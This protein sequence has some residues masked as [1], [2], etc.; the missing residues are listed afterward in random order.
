MKH[1]LK[2]L[3]SKKGMTL[4][5]V[6]IAV[7]IFSLITAAAFSMY[8]PI[9]E[10]AG[11]VRSDNDMQRIVTASENYLARQL[12]NAVEIEIHQTV[13]WASVT[14]DMKAFFENG[15]N[16][17]NKD[18][19]DP[20]A[21]VITTDPTPGAPADAIRIYDIRLNDNSTSPGSFQNLSGGIEKWRVFNTTFYSDIL[22]PTFDVALRGNGALNP[23]PENQVRDDTYLR[24]EIEAE[25]D[26][27][28]GVRSG[29]LASNNGGESHSNILLS[30]IGWIEDSDKDAYNAS[31]LNEA[32][33]C[34]ACSGGNTWVI[35][36]HNNIDMDRKPPEIPKLDTPCPTCSN[37]TCTLVHPA[38]CPGTL[39]CYSEFCMDICVAVCSV[40]N[41]EF[42]HVAGDVDICHF[43]GCPN[44]IN[45]YFVLNPTKCTGK[46]RCLTGAGCVCADRPCYPDCGLGCKTF[47][48]DNAKGR[49]CGAHW[50]QDPCRST[51]CCNC[52]NAPAGTYCDHL[53][54]SCPAF[55]CDYCK[56][57]CNGRPGNPNGGCGQQKDIIKDCLNCCLSCG[58]PPHIGCD[59][60][61]VCN[62]CYPTFP[63][64]NWVED[65]TRPGY[66]EPTCYSEGVMPRYC[67]VCS[68]N[69][70]RPIP[71][72]N[73]KWAGQKWENFNHEQHIKICAAG[74]GYTMHEKHIPSSWKTDD[75]GRRY[76]TCIEA[77]SC[78][79][80]QYDGLFASISKCPT[81]EESVN[82]G[83]ECQRTVTITNNGD[84]AQV[85]G[86]IVAKV[87]PAGSKYVRHYDNEI[88]V[89][90][91]DTEE[92]TDEFAFV[93]DVEILTTQ[94]YEF[95]LT[96][97][98][99][100]CTHEGTG[101]ID[102][103]DQEASCTVA[104]WENRKKCTSCNRVAE[105]TEIPA[106]N[107]VGTGRID[108]DDEEAT[109]TTDGFENRKK[110]GGCF[111]V[112]EDGTTLPA[113]G[114]EPNE[115]VTVLPTCSTPGTKK[116]TCDNCDELNETRPIDALVA[117]FDDGSPKSGVKCGE[118][119][120]IVFK[121]KNCNGSP[122]GHTIE[123]PTGEVRSDNFGEWE[124][125]SPAKC[126]TNQVLKRV[127]L[128]DNCTNFETQD[129]AAATGHDAR[130]DWEEVGDPDDCSNPLIYRCTRC[131]GDE[132]D[133][134]AEEVPATHK[135]DDTK[136]VRFSETHDNYLTH[137]ARECKSC[138]I[139]IEDTKETHDW[140]S[141]S[142][143]EPVGLSCF[144]D[145]TRSKTCG[146]SCGAIKSE[147][148]TTRPDH[149]WDDVY[150]IIP[151]D[152]AFHAQVCK[153][154]IG[155]LGCQSLNLTGKQGHTLSGTWSP[156]DLYCVDVCTANGCGH[157]DSK[158]HSYD[159][160]AKID[161]DECEKECADCHDTKSQL[162]KWSTE[163]FEDDD[164]E[165]QL[166]G[167]V[168][169]GTGFGCGTKKYKPEVNPCDPV[170]VD[171]P[172]PVR[173]VARHTGNW[174][175]SVGGTINI[176][177]NGQ[178]TASISG[179]NGNNNFCD[180]TLRLANS[181]DINLGNN[182]SPAPAAFHGANITFNTVTANGTAGQHNGTVITPLAGNRGPFP[183]V[184][185]FVG[186]IEN[187]TAPV[188]PNHVDARLWNG[189][190]APE[191]RLNG[192]AS[193]GDNPA[194][195]GINTNINSFTVTFTI[196]GVTGAGGHDFTGTWNNT[197]VLGHTRKCINCTEYSNL[198]PHVYGAWEDIGN[199]K[200]ECFCE[201]GARDERDKPAGGLD[202]A[203]AIT[204]GDSSQ[205]N[206]TLSMKVTNTS[207]APITNP[208]ITV[209]IRN[210]GGWNNGPD[211]WNVTYPSNSTLT[212]RY[213][214][215]LS[216][217]ATVEVSW[218]GG[219]ATGVAGFT[220][221][222]TYT[223]VTNNYIAP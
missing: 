57:R 189:W 147:P 81:G 192:V 67:T 138:H 98:M 187:Q 108:V 87:D 164:G 221:N 63:S 188:Y 179:L 42:R 158:E 155:G 31:T 143:G 94:P 96:I 159:A 129:G 104:G 54:G 167:P 47:Q 215:T 100:D 74:C 200:Q 126:K 65:K 17:R 69:A 16:E 171:P 195:F 113:S 210:N 114:H 218:G 139:P 30:W 11:A 153:N 79:W 173:L 176:D 119:D 163:W 178:Y 61:S 166:C 7:V 93:G 102:V 29:K 168:G 23:E 22:F 88:Q 39:P 46:P 71:P 196:N 25:R 217:G 32:R 85:L 99:K 169:S 116:I 43:K 191:R 78:D 49:G 193:N 14:G 38:V 117:D 107:H 84:S 91:N 160:W 128:Y 120:S 151:D 55:D 135:P 161:D 56:Y 80:I 186:Y 121:C 133:D 68:A 181:N 95:G 5:E 15:G 132:G 72:S 40:S 27:K 109:C 137:H 12:R 64:C 86:S 122:V 157:K 118:A 185:T 144:E 124:Q 209:P 149:E 101:R 50:P 145:G 73:H 6:I 199:G 214:G 146:D 125:D 175:T 162:H 52:C 90:P 97:W 222:Q 83:H 66:V 207:T 142:W 106:L 156:S 141:N 3:K 35:L 211:N 36:Y 202:W 103:D 174:A 154:R 115:Q 92:E 41:P 182:G 34:T 9:V 170:T 194:N 111:E 110:C 82:G 2:R 44:C 28:F 219:F 112:V 204:N 51:V 19:D 201:C 208:T 48:S 140:D 58:N 20:R 198:T 18:G 70:T 212:I 136:W 206:A 76:K 130:A 148:V 24:L 190:E 53:S 21:L 10:I 13:S 89:L 205:Y 105:E 220:F 134:G 33:I 197:G 213:N 37:G 60:L 59:D 152:E 177:G 165:Y 203:I 127:C 1:L 131:K 223:S 8:Q 45:D 26:A 123:E 4:I 216:P 150:T 62:P 77:P 184:G 183:L 75:D 172:L 180:L